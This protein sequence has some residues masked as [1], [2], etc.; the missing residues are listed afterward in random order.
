MLQRNDPEQYKAEVKLSLALAAADE[1]ADG[2]TAPLVLPIAEL[3][4]NTSSP[5]FSDR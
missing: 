1:R 2:G 3:A 5:G 4:L